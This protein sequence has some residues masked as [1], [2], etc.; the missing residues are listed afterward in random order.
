MAVPKAVLNVV[1]SFVRAV[2]RL[3]APQYTRIRND[4]DTRQEV[5]QVLISVQPDQLTSPRNVD[6]IEKI[7]VQ[8]KF[9][10]YVGVVLSDSWQ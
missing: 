9:L 7:C 3:P 8:Q 6:A 1:T 4:E 10:G 2:R 5:P